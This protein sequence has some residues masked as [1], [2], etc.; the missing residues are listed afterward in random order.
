MQSGR[1]LREA[2]SETYNTNVF[3]T[4]Q[5]TESFI[6]LLEKSSHPRIVFVSSRLGSF[7]VDCVPNTYPIYRSS[8]SALNMLCLSYSHRF[9]KQGWK[10]NAACP[11][12]VATNLNGFEAPGTVESGAINIVRLATVGKDGETGTFSTKEGPLPW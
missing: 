10:I 7:G 9:E 6:P 12:H 2:F 1:S 5:V 3:G 11:G 4:V 8:K